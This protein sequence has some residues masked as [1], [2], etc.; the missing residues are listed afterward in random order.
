MVFVATALC[1]ARVAESLKG[2]LARIE[3]RSFKISCQ[4]TVSF[5]KRFEFETNKHHK[6]RH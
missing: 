4:M 3:K 1:H 2:G 5:F 6:Q